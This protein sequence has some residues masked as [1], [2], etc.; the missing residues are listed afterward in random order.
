MWRRN[1][2]CVVHNNE[3]RCCCWTSL[4]KRGCF[5]GQPGLARPECAGLSSPPDMVALGSSSLRHKDPLHILLYPVHCGWPASRRNAPEAALG[6]KCIS[7]HWLVPVPVQ[8]LEALRCSTRSPQINVR[9]FRS[10]CSSYTSWT[11]C[12][13]YVWVRHARMSV[14]KYWWVFLAVLTNQPIIKHYKGTDRSI[15][16]SIPVSMGGVCSS[17]Y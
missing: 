5:R 13:Q 10:P 17:V 8:L 6:T 12:R 1:R 7:C 11:G 16:L 3:P 2:S 14:L 15:H 4:G 9:G